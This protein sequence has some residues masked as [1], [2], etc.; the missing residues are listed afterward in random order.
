M[1]LIAFAAAAA[2]AVLSLSVARAETPDT[3][4]T[5]DVPQVEVPTTTD[6]AAD[7]SPT[8]RPVPCRFRC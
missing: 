4:A 3:G 2:L 8:A 6:D 5:V 1:K 7:V